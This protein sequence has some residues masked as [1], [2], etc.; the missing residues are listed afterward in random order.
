LLYQFAGCSLT[1][2]ACIAALSVLH[3]AM[4]AAARMQPNDAPVYF[5]FARML[6]HYQQQPAADLDVDGAAAP[7]LPHLPVAAL[8]VSALMSS[9]SPV[10]LLSAGWLH[11]RQ[12]SILLY[13][14]HAVSTDKL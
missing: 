14:A 2:W 3:A 8:A 12:P 10:L 7:R 6:Q 9:I 11:V 4:P 13:A 5:C 1:L